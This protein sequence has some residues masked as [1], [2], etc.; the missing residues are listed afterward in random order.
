[1]N[2]VIWITGIVIGAVAG[3][4]YWNYIGCNTGTCAITSNWH[5]STL[6]GS[7]MGFLISGMVTDFTKKKKKESV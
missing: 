2:K 4:L 7:F 1:M 5:S 3:F 6:Y